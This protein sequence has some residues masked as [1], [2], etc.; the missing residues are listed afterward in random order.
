MHEQEP[1]TLIDV[2]LQHAS[3][4]PEDILYRFLDAQGHTTQALSFAALV[5]RAQA[6]AAV[7]QTRGLKGETALLMYPP[8]LSFIEALLGCF[9]AGVIAVPVVPPD[10]V[11]LMRSLPR[12]KAIVSDV[13]TRCLLTNRELDRFKDPVVCDGVGISALRW[14]DTDSIPD[15]MALDF[16]PW[17][18]SGK[19]I[20]FLQYTSGSTASPRGV[21]ISHEN[22]MD[23]ERIVAEACSLSA[24]DRGV[25]WLPM[26]H[27]M[28]LLGGVLQPLFSGF[29]VRLLSPITFLKRPITWLR[30][31]SDFKATISPAPN[32][33]YA[34]CTNKID[35]ESVLNL[36]ISSWKCALN[37]SEPIRT[38]VLDHFVR[39]FEP[40]GFRRHAF[41]PCYGLA[42][43]TLL[44]SGA[45]PATAEPMRVVVSKEA[46]QAGRVQTA[47]CESNQTRCLVA[48]GKIDRRHQLHIVD[49]DSAVERG[50]DEVGEIWVRGPSVADGYWNRPEETESVFRARIRGQAEGTYLRTGDLGFLHEGTLVVT[51]RS[52]DLI[53]QRGKNHYPQDIEASV[54]QA[55]PEIV[56]GGVAAFA[57]EE[58]DKEHLAV[59]VEL[60]HR[61]HNEADFK[62]IE[63]AIRQA[64]SLDHDVTVHLVALLEKRTIPKTSSG[65]LQ[66]GVCRAQLASGVL[67]TLYTSVPPAE[68]A[69][70]SESGSPTATSTPA[71]GTIRTADEIR[72]WLMDELSKC[73]P[74]P[75]EEIDPNQPLVSYG[76][77]SYTIMMLVAA[78]EEWL[79]VPIE[80]VVFYEYPTIEQLV[81][82]FSEIAGTP[83]KTIT[84]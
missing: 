3:H 57:L 13:G 31:I 39:K 77:D 65:K 28:G 42:E 52:K 45:K 78:T 67:T 38:E 53:I 66:R 70:N 50:E 46:L 60:G 9:Q 14:I 40:C 19:D 32:F 58:D 83:E 36:D 12:L 23:N 29:P 43:A 76:L 84:I 17:R 16:A 74:V 54:E 2:L 4:R 48:C 34:Y 62:T 59:A 24:A 26:F 64:V 75:Q 81:R 8:G 30:A 51:G 61:K 37:G 63:E 7:L 18:P 47:A 5:S 21:K 22:I 44:V 41:Y 25:S 71:P 69:D 11:R 35:D 56:Q 27:D 55:H 82:H 1:Q 68:H 20:A 6:I 49:P 73:L 15:D 33:A 10:S 80:P 79:V 72:A